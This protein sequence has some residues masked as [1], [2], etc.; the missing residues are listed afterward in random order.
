MTIFVATS[1]FCAAAF[2]MG[3]VPFGLLLGRCKG[4]DVRK[5]GSG[6][7]G[8]ANVARLLGRPWGIATFVLD[9]LKGWIPAMLAGWFLARGAGE[10][11]ASDAWMAVCRLAVG[12]CAVLGHNY[13]PFLGFRGGKGVATS[14][15]VCLGTYPQLTLPGVVSFGVWSVFFGL[16]RMTSVGSLA[17]GVFFPLATFLFIRFLG[18]SLQSDWPFFAFATLLSVLIIVRHRANIVRILSGTESSFRKPAPNSSPGPT[19]TNP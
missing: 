4:I 10:P 18:R 14:L 15:G 3:G 2:L 5:A 16:T 8:A 1:L 7:I 6:N 12:L 19:S 17:A 11:P 9:V 13:S